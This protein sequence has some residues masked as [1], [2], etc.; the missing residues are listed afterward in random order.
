L[1]VSC[2]DMNPPMQ[3]GDNAGATADFRK[4]P[5]IGPGLGDS[6]K[7]PGAAQ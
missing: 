3:T 2:G 4:G 7:R 6:L 1:T 5:G